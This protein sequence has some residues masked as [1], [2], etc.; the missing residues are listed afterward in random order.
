MIL[1][2]KRS[3]TTKYRVSVIITRRNVECFL[4]PLV[5][6]FQE[7]LNKKSNCRFFKIAHPVESQVAVVYNFGFS[8]AAM[9]T[10]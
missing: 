1:C 7:G 3:L 9:I 8:L 5:C 4:R 6:C 10:I 2:V